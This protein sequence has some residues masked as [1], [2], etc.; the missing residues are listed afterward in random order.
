MAAVLAATVT[1]AA[2][3]DEAPYSTYGQQDEAGV[4]PGLEVSDAKLVLAPIEGNPAAIYA[5]ISYSGDKLLAISGAEVEGA[6]NAE[7]H[8]TMEWEGKMAMNKANPIPVKKGEKLSLVPG[9]A[10]IMAFE[11]P[12]GLKAGDKVK[13]SLRLAGARTHDFEATVQEAGEER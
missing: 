5:E 1:L 11:L 8:Q 2:C 13:A 12:A 9:E 10:H 4:I 6:K 7:V 3:E